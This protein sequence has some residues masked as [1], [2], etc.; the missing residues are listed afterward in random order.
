MWGRFKAKAAETRGNRESEWSNW[1]SA[2][3]HSTL[4][5]TDAVPVG[6]GRPARGL[7]VPAA[8]LI[9]SGARPLRAE[10]AGMDEFNHSLSSDDVW[11]HNANGP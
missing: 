8:R 6:V 9:D 4:L 1:Q 11:P 10:F 3:W 7:R 5:P 2:D